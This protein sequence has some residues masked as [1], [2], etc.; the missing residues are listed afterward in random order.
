MNDPREQMQVDLKTAM[1]A[2]DKQQ[3]M[4]LRM[5][6]NAIKQEEIDARVT[7]DAQDATA[8][9]MREAKKR[10]ESITE[11]EQHGRDDLASTEKEELV[12][13]EK[14]LPQQM[15][16]EAITALVKDAIAQTGASSPKEMGK[17]M[18]VLMPKVKGQADGKLVNQIVRDLLSEVE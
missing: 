16:A 13:L 8:I 18:G 9:L 11:A 1:R 14:Y 12:I 7:L 2:K 10:R 4:V 6:L 17:I 5:A 15:S 3:I